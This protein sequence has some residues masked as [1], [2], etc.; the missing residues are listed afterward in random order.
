M[1]ITDLNFIGVIVFYIERRAPKITSCYFTYV[2]R[3]CNNA[4]HVLAKSVEIDPGS[5]WFNEVPDA[6]KD[7]VFIGQSRECMK[8][9]IISLRKMN[10]NEKLFAFSR[11]KVSL[12]KIPITS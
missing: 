3:Y 4:P 10:R 2:S 1:R 5:H 9:P 11:K 7:V 12:R 6:I 8:L